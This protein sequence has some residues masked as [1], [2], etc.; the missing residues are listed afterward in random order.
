MCL[1][2]KARTEADR[3]TVLERP[4]LRIGLFVSLVV[5]RAG[6]GRQKAARPAGPPLRGGT[7]A[8]GTTSTPPSF[9]G[10]GVPQTDPR[11]SSRRP[12]EIV[13]LWGRFRFYAGG[14]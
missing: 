14:P 5:R 11:M 9:L 6:L 10:G 3:R 8:G 4:L 2:E 7:R 12:R 1:P 13:F